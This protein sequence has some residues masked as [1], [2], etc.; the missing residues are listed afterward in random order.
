MKIAE[1]KEVIDT[2]NWNRNDLS[3]AK[4]PSIGGTK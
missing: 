1:I 2:L 3:E 4:T